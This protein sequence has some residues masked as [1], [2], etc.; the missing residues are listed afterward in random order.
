M[1]LKAELIHRV[2]KGA[3][4]TKVPDSANFCYG[5]KYGFAS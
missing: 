5:L 2:P 3:N 4:P 1:A